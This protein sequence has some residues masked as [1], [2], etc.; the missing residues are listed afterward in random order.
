MNLKI[1][2]RIIYIYEEIRLHCIK[3]KAI[4]SCKYNYIIGIYTIIILNIIIFNVVIYNITTLNITTLYSD[5]L[6]L[7]KYIA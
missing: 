4:K 3:F 5:T 1:S 6:S 2:L 7:N